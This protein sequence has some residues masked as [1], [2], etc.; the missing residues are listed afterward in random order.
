MSVKRKGVHGDLRRARKHAER[1]SPC[2]RP[3]ATPTGLVAV[4]DRDEGGRGSARIRARVRWQE[5]HTDISGFAIRIDR[6]DL[7]VQYS[8]DSVN[9]FLRS[10]H[11]VSAKD[12]VDPNDKA[13]II[14][15]GFKGRLYYR[16]RVRAVRGD[17]KSEW[18]DWVVLGQPVPE[19]PPAPSRVK[20]IPKQHPDRVR[21]E[22]DEVPD[23]NDAL[24]RT[25]NQDW[26]IVEVATDSSFTNLV[27]R[28]RKVHTTHISVRVQRNQVYYGRVRAVA[29]GDNHNWYSAWVPA[30]TAGNSD[31]NAAPEG[32]SVGADPRAP[33]WVTLSFDESERARHDRW[34]AVV[35]WAELTD[36]PQDEAA[37]RYVVQLQVSQS[38]PTVVATRKHTV[39]AKDEDADTVA[40]T[41][42]GG[43]RR[44]YYY[45]ARV[46]AVDR[47]GLRG[48][49]SGWTAWSRPGGTVPAPTNVRVRNPA[50]RR[51]VAEWDDPPDA[52]DIEQYRVEVLRGSTV[53]ETGYT[54]SRRYAYRVP[55]ADKGQSHSVRVTALDPDGNSSASAS[56]LPTAD[57]DEI[58]GSDVVA[59]NLSEI[60][61]DLGYIRA[62]TIE[63]AK[64]RTSG[65]TTRVELVDTEPDRVRFVSGGTAAA[66]VASGGNIQLIGEL[67]FGTSWLHDEGHIDLHNRA[68][69][70]EA[71][72]SAVRLYSMNG[73]LYYRNGQGQV[74]GPL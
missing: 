24:R 17:C 63:G 34:R 10:R 62:G 8:A 68:S 47:W 36:D 20:I 58:R 66:L 3:P 39:E 56:S 71:P 50:P 9:W 19:N 7:E 33:A 15:R 46:R 48:P 74:F 41:R 4:W 2:N 29:D 53:V 51:I 5:V 65:G 25:D 69:H 23:D 12:D 18:S 52:H 37:S 60:S 26:F 57:A 44:R 6:Y 13:H 55:R 31:P 59:T 64:I 30:T 14:L 22:W 42:F 38:P 16:C 11:R 43:I 32:V 67:G 1:V 54:R 28:L 21:L 49:W 61:S 73:R 27:K 40:S 35:T 72:V 45:R 70:P